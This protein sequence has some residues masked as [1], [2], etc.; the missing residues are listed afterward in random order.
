MVLC[1][2]PPPPHP[3]ITQLIDVVNN[4]QPPDDF[5]PLER[6]YYVEYQAEQPSLAFPRQEAAWIV[7]W[8]NNPELSTTARQLQSRGYTLEALEEARKVD[9]P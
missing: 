8:W 7:E 1:D 3:C 6:C 5:E 9:N 2:R 4:P